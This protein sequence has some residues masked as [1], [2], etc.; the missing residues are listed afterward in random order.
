MEGI[1]P[2]TYSS[3]APPL[4]EDLL[5]P[6]SHFRQKQVAKWDPISKYNYKVETADP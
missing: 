2:E 6:R 1:R 3:H 5:G 4:K